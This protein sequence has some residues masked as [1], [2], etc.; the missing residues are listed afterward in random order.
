MTLT[1]SQILKMPL[2]TNFI[3]NVKFHSWPP[4]LTDTFTCYKFLSSFYQPP[5]IVITNFIS[6]L[7]RR[8]H[9]RTCL[10][11]WSRDRPSWIPVILQII[12]HEI[13]ENEHKQYSASK[14]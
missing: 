5:V 10:Q 4:P 8:P 14:Q 3:K 7:V 1:D 6:L 2:S 9:S 12:N 11:L 13:H